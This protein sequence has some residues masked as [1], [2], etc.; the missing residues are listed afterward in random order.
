MFKRLR[1]QLTLVCAVG[2]GLVL[3]G[4]ALAA[5]GVSL[6]QLELQQAAAFRSSLN[7]VFFYLRGTALIDQTWLAQTEAD[8]G[9][10]LRVEAQGNQ[11]QYTGQNPQREALTRLAQDHALLEYGFDIGR[12]PTSTLAP[13][14]VQFD[15]ELDGVRYRT[16][17]AVVPY[18]DSWRGVTLLKSRLPEEQLRLGL[19]LGFMACVGMGILLLVGFAWIFTGAAIRPVERA[20][21]KQTEFVSAASHELRSPLS[22]IEMSAGTIRN[23]PDQAAAMADKIEGECKRL[24]RLMGDLLLLAGSDSGRVAMETA[25]ASPKTVVLSTYERFELL[26]ASQNIALSVQLPEAHLADIPCDAQR[27]EQV[28]GIFLDNALSYTPAGGRIRLSVTG[29]KRSVSF[30]VADSGPGIPD[31]E[32]AR[33]FDRFYRADPSRTKKEHYGLGLSVAREIASLHKGHIQV[34]DG[35]LGG[36]EFVLTLSRA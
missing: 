20:Q 29:R 1:L 34:R 12:K 9:L 11:L 2:T 36:A 13:D 25:T 28:L 10:W 35:E 31:G 22:V 5:L 30:H 16:A 3:A 18:S 27:I 19:R 4:M 7:S 32:K 33:V 26:A 6:H 14:M 24:S 8:G 23:I 15:L 21:R 17:V